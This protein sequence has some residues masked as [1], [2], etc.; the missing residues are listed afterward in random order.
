LT[1]KS[2]RCRT[3]SSLQLDISAPRTKF[4]VRDAGVKSFLVAVAVLGAIAIVVP[5]IHRG[6]SRKPPEQ[7]DFSSAE[8]HA[9]E[10][11]LARAQVF[12]ADVPDTLSLNLKANWRD[13][14]PVADAQPLTCHY[15]SQETSGTSPKFDCRLE[16]GTTIK[17]KYGDSP[18]IAAEVAATRLLAALGFGADYVTRVQQ[19]R[20]LGCPPSPYRLR[21][22]F[23]HL[24]IA[25]VFDKLLDD[26]QPRVFTNVS[27]E[28][29]LEGRA[30][31]VGD[32]E[33]W[34]FDELSRIE[35]KRGGATRAE[36]DALR[37]MTVL[38]GHWDNKPSNQRLVCLEDSTKDEPIGTACE[39]PLVL[40]ND[41]GSTFGARSG[42]FDGWAAAPIWTDATNC[43]A[44]MPTLPYGGGT[45]AAVQ[46]TEEGR[47]ILGTRLSQLSEQQVRDLFAGAGYGA[48]EQTGPAEVAQWSDAFV[49]KVRDIVNRPPC[50]A[51]AASLSSR[52]LPH[53]QNR[54]RRTANGAKLLRDAQRVVALEAGV[55]H[56]HREVLLAVHHVGDRE[57]VRDVVEARAF[58]Q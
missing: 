57:R 44:A 58:P 52:Q 55:A 54:R 17:V 24:F 25:G 38:L 13:E 49:A 32:V 33:G 30:V 5:A 18:E 46:I 11:A 12:I 31:E 34:S 26:G 15:L 27:V 37:L 42:G 1:R 40:L 9:R 22:T 35:A 50:P 20:C 53:P 43:T 7:P 45:F 3:A 6:I 4:Q 19:V 48:L 47:R 39:E 10:D 28:R 51:R 29:K 41:V 2:T 14:Q 23:E 56:R 36:V 16:S 8:W 21:R